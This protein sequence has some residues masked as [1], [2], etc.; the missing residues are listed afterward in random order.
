MRWEGVVAWD[1]RRCRGGIDPEREPHGEQG[2]CPEDRRQRRDEAK[3]RR[4]DG[5]RQAQ[6][7]AIHGATH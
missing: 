7:A 6:G 2:L 5:E 3:L 1:G 4:D